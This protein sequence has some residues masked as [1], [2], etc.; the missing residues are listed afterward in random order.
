MTWAA[1]CELRAGLSSTAVDEL[2]SIE[3]RDLRPQE[4]PEAVGVLA[5]GMRDNPL[6][7]AAYGDDPERRLRCH[8]RLMRGL[9]RAF[10]AQQP[11]CA[12]RDGTLVGVTGVA[13]VG[14]C[15]PTA[16]QRLRLL[17]TLVALGPRTAA[18]V[19]KWISTWAKRDP[20]EAHVHLGPLAVDAHLQGQGIGSLIM[21]E[22]CRRLDGAREVGY[23]ETDKAENVG[24][25]ERFGFEVI[26]EE[27]VLGARNW[28][29]RRPPAD[30]R[31]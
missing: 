19:G 30:S 4:G 24:F 21:H 3:V 13:P 22:H 1:Y 29:M 8:A 17:P 23:L 11:I 18:R 14:T 5:R 9:F 16:T 26:G 20:D 10:T 31:S 7:V 2:G 15:Q 27:P 6:H 28:F 25:Y 12:I